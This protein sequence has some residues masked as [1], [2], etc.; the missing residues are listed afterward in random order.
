MVLIKERKGVA[1]F[2]V[3]LF[4]QQVLMVPDNSIDVLVIQL[5]ER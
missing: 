2:R 3:L 1:L 4:P 5:S